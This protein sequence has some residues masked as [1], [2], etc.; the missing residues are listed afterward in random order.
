MAD[1]PAATDSSPPPRGTKRNADAMGEDS[2]TQ[3][4]QRNTKL[5]EIVPE[6]DVTLKVGTGDGAL[7]IKVSGL[8]LGLASK[9]FKTMLNSQ[10]I[11]GT[12]RVIELPEDDPRIIMDF[13]HIIHHKPYLV[14]D[15]D[16][17][18]LRG[19]V[20]LIDLRLCHDSLAPWIV[21]K[22][23]QYVR[24]AET[25]TES[26]KSLVTMGSEFPAQIPG[27]LMEDLIAFAAVFDLPEWFSTATRIYQTWAGDPLVPSLKTTTLSRNDL[28]PVQ[29]CGQC[30]Y[31]EQVV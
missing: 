29:S 27:L 12:T 22:L 16:A 8:I 7:D 15:L 6:A 18:R 2:P 26:T 11:E 25:V 17:Q 3:P 20:K 14:K 1:D 13:A 23:N 28:V 24:W 4:A 19:L 31:G 5:V 21:S 10:F 30:L 9:V